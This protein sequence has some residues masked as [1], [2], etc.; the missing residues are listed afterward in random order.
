VNKSEQKK[1]PKTTLDPCMDYKRVHSNG[2]SLHLSC[3][4]PTLMV[5]CIC[6]SPTTSW[7]GSLVNQSDLRRS[8]TAGISSSCAAVGRSRGFTLIMA[9]STATKS[10]E[11]IL[12]KS[13]YL[14][15]CT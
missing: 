3:P 14:P 7:D 2:I 1:A 11:Y 10:C 5:P 15:D 13:G 9:L 12:G 8:A 4:P 6:T